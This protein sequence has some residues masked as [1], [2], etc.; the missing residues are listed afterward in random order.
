MLL[1]GLGAL[2]LTV[3]AVLGGYAAQAKGRSR[4]EGHVFGLLLGPLGI[5]IVA[6][7]PTLEIKRPVPGQ[8]SGQP[9]ISWWGRL[10]GDDR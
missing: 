4:S 2:A 6:M 1:I 5:L 10:L 8:P 9:Q 7:L 3:C